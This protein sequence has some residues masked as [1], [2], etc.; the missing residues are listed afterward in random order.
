MVIIEYVV[1][2]IPNTILLYS[3]SSIVSRFQCLY[4]ISCKYCTMI[5][6]IYITGTRVI[7]ITRG[8]SEGCYSAHC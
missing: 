8:V 7:Y 6:V 4:I 2:I 1:E 3:N 5:Q